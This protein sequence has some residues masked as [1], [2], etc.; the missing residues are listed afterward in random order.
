RKT[1]NVRLRWR[2]RVSMAIILGAHEST[3]RPAKIIAIETRARQRKR[4]LSVFLG[5]G[6]FQ[7]GANRVQIGNRLLPAD[8]RFQVSERHEH[9]P[10]PARVQ[11]ISELS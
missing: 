10:V 6:F 9:P 4:T 8:S 5:V 2:A 7:I 1:L 11:I 3:H